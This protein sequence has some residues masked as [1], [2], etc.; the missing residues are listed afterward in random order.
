MHKIYWKSDI[1]NFGDELNKDFFELATHVPLDTVRKDEAILGI[2]SILDYKT[3]G[4]QKIH[5][6]GTGSGFDSLNIPNK[7]DYKFWFV[8]GPMTAAVLGIDPDLALTDPAILIPDVYN[9]HPAKTSTYRTL[10]IPHFLSSMNADWETACES[11]GIHYRPPTSSLF[12]ICADICRSQM[13]ITESLHGAIIADAYRIPWILVATPPIARSA[14]KWHDWA[15]SMNLKYEP[16]HIPWLWTRDMT[17]LK[18]FDGAIKYGLSRLSI[19]PTRWSTKRFTTHG[20]AEIERCGKIL[21]DISKNQKP[22]LSPD[23]VLDDLKSKM[24]IKLNAFASYANSQ[25]R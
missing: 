23:G 14:F 7:R 25:E 20:K 13:V 12:E 4:Y 10:F 22:T 2:G 17:L 5:V 15:A 9:L 11:N 16:V 19:G 24:K 8:R 6:L 21:L 18:R 3:E 1:Q